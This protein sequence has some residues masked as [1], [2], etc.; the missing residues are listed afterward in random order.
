[1]LDDC[2][3]E[4]NDDKIAGEEDEGKVDGNIGIMLTLAVSQSR[5]PWT[6]REWREMEQSTV[7]EEEDSTWRR[8]SRVLLHEATKDGGDNEEDDDLTRQSLPGEQMEQIEA[9]S[10]TIQ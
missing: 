5:T 3:N 4:N 7:C 2:F 6:V 1:M 10:E 9:G 8:R